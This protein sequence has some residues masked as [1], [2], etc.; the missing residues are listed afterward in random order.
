M[1]ALSIWISTLAR[2]IA[3]AAFLANSAS[4]ADSVPILSTLTAAQQ[5]KY[6][7]VLAIAAQR[8]AVSKALTTGKAAPAA[9]GATAEAK[10]LALAAATPHCT[11]RDDAPQAKTAPLA[12]VPGKFS[13]KV[14][15]NQRLAL[16]SKAAPAAKGPVNWAFVGLPG[17]AAAGSGKPK[18][19]LAW[20][21][22]AG[23]GAP[24]V[25]PPPS[26]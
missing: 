21:V 24:K 2:P 16:A 23:P 11:T 4:A 12:Y 10:A 3:L 25:A 14:S 9:P 18:P 1:R 22:A 8:P 20:P 13:A 19:Q 15:L 5:A 6:A 26:P 7:D 17:K